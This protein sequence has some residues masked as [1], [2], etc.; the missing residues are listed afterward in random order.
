MGK[1]CDPQ[2]FS[3]DE[4]LLAH[5]FLFIFTRLT[6][7]LSSLWQCWHLPLRVH[8]FWLYFY[9][10]S[11]GGSY[12]RGN[13]WADVQGTIYYKNSV[14]LSLVIDP[15]ITSI[16]PLSNSF[17]SFFLDFPLSLLYFSFLLSLSIMERP[18]LRCHFSVAELWTRILSCRLLVNIC[19]CERILTRQ[20]TRNLK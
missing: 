6:G 5:W 18:F 9:I 10:C 17:L 1:L 7:S 19:K 20:T 2:K 12:I 8:T 16:W 4:F 14:G 15:F 11:W 3:G 13:T